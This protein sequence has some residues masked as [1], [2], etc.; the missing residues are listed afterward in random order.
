[1]QRNRSVD[2]V[3]HLIKEDKKVLGASYLKHLFVFGGGS[4]PPPYVLYF[5]NY[6]EDHRLSLR[7]F[8]EE[9]AELIAHGVFDL[10]AV[11]AA[12]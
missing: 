5:H 10:R 11:S 2:S 3:V 1:M 9:A 6:R 4:K 12:A 8:E 7:L